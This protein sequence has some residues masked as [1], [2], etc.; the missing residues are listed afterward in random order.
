MPMFSSRHAGNAVAELVFRLDRHGDVAA[1]GGAGRRCHEY[2]AVGREG[3][4][5]EGIRRAAVQPGRDCCS[6]QRV[7]SRSI[8]DQIAENG[9]T[10][11]VG[12]DRCG[13]DRQ[14]S[15]GNANGNR[16]VRVG[17]GVAEG[18]GDLDGH[19]NAKLPAATLLG[20]FTNTTSEYAACRDSE[21]AL[22]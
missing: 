2:Q 6:H 22:R 5:N 14:N 19:G 4:D 18:V 3:V 8:L 17:D 13:A 11:G 21:R 16:D 20:E 1:R 15:R 12:Q 9:L 10:Q 7:G